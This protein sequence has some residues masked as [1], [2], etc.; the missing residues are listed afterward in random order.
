VEEIVAGIWAAVLGRERVGAHDGF[1]D[2]GGHSL[3]AM[4]VIARVGEA[5]GAD[6]PLRAIFESPTVAGLAERVGAVLSTAGGTPPLP[7]RRVSREGELVASFGQE[8]LWQAWKSD[9]GSAAYNLHYRLRLRGRVEA[10]VL[11]QALAEVVRRHESLRTTFRE[12]GGGVVQVIHPA[13]PVLLRQVDLGGLAG[14]ARDEAVESLAAGETHRPFDLERGPLLRPVLARLGEG[15]FGFFLTLHHIVTDGGST[16]VLM[17]ELSTLYA[18]F[19][20]GEGSPLPEPE[21]QY[22]D[23]AAWQRASL[24]DELLERQLAY[25]TA[26]LAGAP[27]RPTLRTD[28]PRPPVPSHRAA[29]RSFQ[30]PEEVTAALRALGRR[31]GCTL[32]M[33]LLAGFQALLA[34]QGGHDDICVGTPVAGRVRREL[35]DL[36]G[37][38]ANT[39]V[40]R[41]DLSGSPGFRTLLLR[42]REAALGAY[43]HQDLPFTRLVGALRPECGAG[44]MPL[45]QVVFEL[46]HA[47]ARQEGLR[48]PAVAPITPGRSPGDRQTLRS[49]LR[50]TMRDDGSHV[51]GTLAYRTEL[52]DPATIERMIADYLALLRGGVADPD[53]PVVDLVS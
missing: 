11:E 1:F 41:T 5:F 30:L 15:D 38:F 26:R 32:Y 14:P 39:L 33:T 48:P 19:A 27:R 50:L 31:E 3:L 49:E 4:R 7:L 36:I 21:V 23:Y 24:T 45:F 25:W 2:L 20:A 43:A 52:F 29:T 42:V 10:P 6:L 22:A 51:A 34:R 12:S 28:R 47:R 17:R 8:R 35:E 46:E 18:A 40:I 37:F 44:E 9:P 53:R 13:G 16:G